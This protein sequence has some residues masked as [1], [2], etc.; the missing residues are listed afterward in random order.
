[1]L[2]LRL[3]NY[4]RG[5]VIILVEGYFL[6]KFINICIHRQIFLWDINRHKD[7][8]M[9]LKVS[10]KGFK[11]LRPVIKKTRCRAKI[12]KKRGMPF[13]LNRYRS[14]K[15]FILGAFAFA[16]LFY[17]LTSFIWAVEIYGNNKVDSQILIDKLALYGARPGSFKFRVDTNKIADN[18]MLEIK[19]LSWI[20]VA[21][22]GTKIKVT[23]VERVKPPQLIPKD[24]P[25]DIIAYRDGVV[26]SITAKIGQ[27]SIKVGDTVTKGQVLI[28]GTLISENK[29]VAPKYVHSTGEVLARTWYES[30][31][32]VNMKIQEKVRTG[33][34][35]DNYTLVLF[36]KPIKLF[37][38]SKLYENY[39][40]IEIK[41]KLSI[42]E[43]LILPFGVV[44]DR[45][46]ENQLVER[47]IDLEEAKRIAADKAYKEA[48]DQISEEAKVV[49]R[50][51][52]FIEKD[53]GG[54]IASVVVECL[55]NIGIK[56]KIGGN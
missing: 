48:A 31:V 12:L 3:W 34:K 13:L 44:V 1:M 56:E 55:E 40:R 9:T 50:E 37:H 29:E 30:R 26:K 35:K 5:Y 41:K 49:K 53:D 33:K 51:L 16:F 2:L 10:I 45:Y 24:E 11:M 6:E 4:L 38:K 19:E 43:D 39:D 27:K 42:G 20:G 23:V 7:S 36:S 14:R 28:S 32:P 21:L 17:V 52:D 25:C 18:M 54:L 22:K 15:T 46:Y 47:E 8:S